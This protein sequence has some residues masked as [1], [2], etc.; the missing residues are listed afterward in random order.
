MKIH[1]KREIRMKPH[2]KV[3]SVHEWRIAVGNSVCQA[4]PQKASASPH[5][6]WQGERQI[7]QAP[8]AFPKNIMIAFSVG[9]CHSFCTC[10]DC[11][12]NEA[13]KVKRN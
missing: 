6:I 7:I 1:I 2:R 11:F 8:F 13:R 4:H 5:L 10:K 12:P 3:S 9:L